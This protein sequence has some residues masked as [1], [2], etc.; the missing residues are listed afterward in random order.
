MNV[1]CEEISC[2]LCASSEVRDYYADTRRAY[3]CCSQCGLVYVPPKFFP[4][5]DDEK[6][7]YDL[8]RNSA[9]D[10]GYVRFLS[11]LFSPLHQALRPGSSGLDFGSGPEPVLAR[12]FEDAGHIVTRFDPWYAPDHSVF[13]RQYDFITLSEVA[14][15]LRDPRSELDRL[16]TC[17]R[18]GGMLGIM[19]QPIVD[20][21]A[22]PAW[23]YKNDLTHLCFF[24]PEAFAWLAASW[25]AELSIPEKDVFLL[26]K[27]AD[28]T[29]G[30]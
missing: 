19:T 10:E 3:L 14:E 8:H 2:P 12:M 27:T 21:D 20:R 15:H 9:D 16:W 7:R 30:R 5:P 4:S 25:Q 22:F 23:H 26:K 29:R 11:R 18:P 17:L 13:D 24:S 1:F 28:G 6:K